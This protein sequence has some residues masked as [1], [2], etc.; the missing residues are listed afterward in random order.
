M[1]FTGSSPAGMRVSAFTTNSS[2]YRHEDNQKLCPSPIFCTKD[3]RIQFII[4]LSDIFPTP[5]HECTDY[6]FTLMIK[7]TGS[8]LPKV[9]RKRGRKEEQ[10]NT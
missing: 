5:L 10:R 8:G 6:G 9:K 7:T 3:S 4:V 1:R 2:Q